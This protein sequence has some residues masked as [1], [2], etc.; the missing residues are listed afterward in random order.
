MMGEY[1]PVGAYFTPERVAQAKSQPCECG[2]Q[3]DQECVDSTARKGE[4]V[5]SLR[6]ATGRPVHIARCR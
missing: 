1:S 6:E 2:A 3:I 5:R 4:P